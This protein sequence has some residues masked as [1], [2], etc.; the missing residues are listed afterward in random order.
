[1]SDSDIR[2]A[3]ALKVSAT[4]Q[5]QDVNQCW[6]M[7]IQ[8]RRLLPNVKPALVQHLVFTGYMCSIVEPCSERRMNLLAHSARFC[9]M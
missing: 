4:Q 1:M 5:T 9:F 3:L 8:H 6:L 2:T 7:L